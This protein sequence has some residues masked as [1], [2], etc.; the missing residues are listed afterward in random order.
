M[1]D[2]SATNELRCVTFGLHWTSGKRASGTC[3]SGKG[4]SASGKWASGECAKCS[5]AGQEAVGECLC[6]IC[7]ID[8]RSVEED[9]AWHGS[10]GSAA[11][12]GNDSQDVFGLGG[13]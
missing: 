6:G 7:G 11:D 4:A 3:T 12:A 8:R 5:S 2:W 9:A 10:C 13:A 1:S